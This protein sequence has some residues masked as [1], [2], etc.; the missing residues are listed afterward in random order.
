[1]REDLINKLLNE[2][3][4]DKEL[5]KKNLLLAMDKILL[6]T[7]NEYEKIRLT[8]EITKNEK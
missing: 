4:K 5:I 2:F 1:M 6:E 7:N 3:D 8:I